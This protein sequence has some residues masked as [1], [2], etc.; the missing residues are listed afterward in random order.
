MATRLI[1]VMPLAVLFAASLA[2]PATAAVIDGTSGPDVLVGTAKA[3]RIH[4]FGGRDKIYGKA[5][6]DRI[7]GGRDNRRDL[8]NGGPGGD[9][10]YARF[11]DRVNA[12]G[13]N[14]VITIGRAAWKMTY[15]SCG[16]GY[17]EVHHYNSWL[18]AVRGCEKL[19]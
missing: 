12:G 6:A 18:V 16:P 15:V 7:H 11:G 3:D 1:R 5:G 4:G 13:G 2:V 14:D 19:S 9:R 10:I 8:L 17:D